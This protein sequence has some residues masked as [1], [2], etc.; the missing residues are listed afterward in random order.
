M[1]TKLQMNHSLNPD[2]ICRTPSGMIAG[3]IAGPCSAETE[4]QTLETAHAL[5][6]RG[7]KIFRAGIWK[8]RTKPGGFEGVGTVGLGWLK[9]VKRETGM[10]VA[11]EVATKEHVQAA[12]NAEIDLLWIGAR[13]TV[14]PFTVQE[15]A[16]TLRGVDIPVFIKNPVNPDLELWLGAIERFQRAGIRRLGAIHRGFSSYE[17]GSYRNPPIWNIPLELKRL[18]P[19]LPV[20]CDPSHIS[21]KRELIESVSQHALDCGFDGL[22]IESHCHPDDAWSDAAQQV[23]P[24][25]LEEILERLLAKNVKGIR[26][27][28]AFEENKTVASC[29]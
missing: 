13:T 6:A 28:M 23:T 22:M 26:P 9:R 10:I 15:I 4:K 11:T 14:N 27:T 20:F 3:V 1:I 18:M 29:V 8:P 7:I 17:K 12:L 25:S 16:D 24:D 2:G 19:E 21:G 5:A